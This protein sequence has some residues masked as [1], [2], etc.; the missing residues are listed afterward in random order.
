MGIGKNVQQ[1]REAKKLTLDAVALA[2]GTNPQ[3]ISQMEK[4]DSKT[5]SFAPKLAQFFGVDLAAL[6]SDDL[7]AVTSGSKSDEVR[8]T[9]QRL[10]WVSEREAELL[11]N[12]RACAEAEQATID[13]I[14]KSLPKRSFAQIGSDQF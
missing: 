1:L 13:S 9:P 11:S 10:Q 2:V 7:Y 8:P 5:S 3:A 6:M 4:R 12:Y 14:A